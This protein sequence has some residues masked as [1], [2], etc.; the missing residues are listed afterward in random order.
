MAGPNVEKVLLFQGDSITDCGRNYNDKDNL[1]SGYALMI[2][3]KLGLTYPEKKIR[4]L[5]RGISGNLVVDLR[6]RWEEDCIRLNPSWVSIMVGINEVG[7]KYKQGEPT[8]TEAYYEGYKEL[9]VQTIEKT[10]AKIILMEPFLLPVDDVTKQWREDLD[11]KIQAVRELAREFNT[12][13]VPLD[14]LFA[15]AIT[16]H[17]MTYY[18]PDGIHPTAAGHALISEAWMTAISGKSFL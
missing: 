5:N 1:G 8:S 3:G 14:G 6:A 13:Y 11:P 2:S 9:L 17:D 18:A 4:F 10:G 15:A 7:R 12:L 16:Q